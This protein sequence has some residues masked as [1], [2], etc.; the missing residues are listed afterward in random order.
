M[1]AAG[2]TMSKIVSDEE[3]SIF[4]PNPG[5]ISDLVNAGACEV[6]LDSGDAFSSAGCPMHS[7]W[8]KCE[9]LHVPFAF[10]YQNGGCLSCNKC[11]Q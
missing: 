4:S 2:A 11:F 5:L 8:F 3:F 7:I 6:S 10:F 9:V 1:V